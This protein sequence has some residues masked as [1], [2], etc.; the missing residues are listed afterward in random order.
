MNG[1]SE[2][3]EEP[4]AGKKPAGFG[5]LAQDER[6]IVDRYA[7]LNSE[8]DAE[9]KEAISNFRSSL[10]AWSADA[11]SRSR[12]MPGA[13]RQSRVWRLA[14]GWALGSVLVAGALCGGVYERHHKQELARIA[15]LQAVERQRLAV[16][17]R[18]QD[19]EDLLAK[20]DSDVSREVPSAMEPLAQLMAEDENR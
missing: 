2:F 16:Q 6:P 17:Q 1:K 7:E 3:A 10:H 11:Y 13:A 12:Y 8:L 4:G 5:N 20:V 19:E 9:L 18:A 14:A 15:A